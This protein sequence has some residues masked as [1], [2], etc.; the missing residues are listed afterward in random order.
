M[1]AA[2]HSER[3]FSV[4][5]FTLAHNT[6]NVWSGVVWGFFNWTFLCQIISSVNVK[7]SLRWND[8]NEHINLFQQKY[9]CPH[10][11][12]R[13]LSVRWH[14][15]LSWTWPGD[16]NQT[17]TPFSNTPVLPS[18]ITQKRTLIIFLQQPKMCWILH[19]QK[20]PTLAQSIAQSKQCLV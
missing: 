10:E 15:L 17:I 6:Q 9:L 4:Y 11:G 12:Q 20:D 18:R 19:K 13:C 5:E 16:W 2:L 1:T 7:I 14:T 3:S 8:D